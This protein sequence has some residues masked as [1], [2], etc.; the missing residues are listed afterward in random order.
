VTAELVAALTASGKTVF[1]KRRL[2]ANHPR[3]IYG[4]RARLAR[5]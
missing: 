1:E 4:A 2:H 3:E 5:V